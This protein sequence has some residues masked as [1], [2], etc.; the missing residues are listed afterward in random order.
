MLSTQRRVAVGFV[1]ACLILYA[2]GLS[3]TL[4]HYNSRDNLKLLVHRLI[5]VI[6]F[7]P[8]TSS[9][10]AFDSFLPAGRREQRFCKC[11]RYL[12]YIL[13]KP[14]RQITP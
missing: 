9:A 7:L 14:L 8:A 5:W 10:C 2:L 3:Y 1:L 12:T 6:H 11:N 4:A 13:T